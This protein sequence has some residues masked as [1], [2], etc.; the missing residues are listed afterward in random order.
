MKV[1]GT[2]YIVD[3]DPSC[4]NALTRLLTAAG[5]NVQSHASGAK[6]LVNLSAN[7]FADG[8]SCVLADLCMPGLDGL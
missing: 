1:S 3:D 4:R 6:L 5:L 2:V 7:T 8:C